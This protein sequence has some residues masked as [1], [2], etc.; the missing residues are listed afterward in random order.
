MQCMDFSSS[1]SHLFMMVSVLLGSGNDML[2]YTSVDQYWQSRGVV[3]SVE[4]M[5]AELKPANKDGDISELIDALGAKEFRVREDASKKILARGEAAIPQLEQVVRSKRSAEILFRSRALLK[6]LKG[7]AACRTTRRLMAIRALG[8]LHTKNPQALAMLRSLLHS[9]KP[10]EAEFAKYAIA[11]IEGKKLP[12]PAGPSQAELDEDIW[13]L[14]R[15]CHLVMQL[16][17]TDYI[18]VGTKWLVRNVK[19]DRYAPSPN[20]PMLQAKK[21]HA[22]QCINMLINQIGNARIDAV[23]I[24]ATQNHCF[25]ILRGQY[26]KKVLKAFLQKQKIQVIQKGSLDLITTLEPSEDYSD[27]KMATAPSSDPW[28]VLESYRFCIILESN[29]RII[30]IQPADTSWWCQVLSAQGEK[31]R[32]SCTHVR[33]K[34]YKPAFACKKDVKKGSEPKP[35]PK[36]ISS[37][38]KM[39]TVLAS[40]EKQGSLAKNAKMAALIR[41]ADRTKPFWVVAQLRKTCNVKTDTDTKAKDKPTKSLMSDQITFT[42]E[43]RGE[44]FHG[45][46]K[47]NGAKGEQIGKAVNILDKGLRNTRSTVKS[48]SYHNWSTNAISRF[49]WRL[50]AK[51][52]GDTIHL[53]TKA[54]D[55]MMPS[56]LSLINPFAQKTSRLLKSS[57]VQVDVGK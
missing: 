32:Q 30:C 49:L 31:M 44:T 18:P 45:T 38:E 10:F 23:T 54:T 11:K 5:V 2:D 56:V 25:T 51:Q 6:D 16:A 39:V 24:G 26:D 13:L 50:Q 22:D 40:K 42:A 53:T 52:E 20:I 36:K 48:W 27:S 47:I 4:N 21:A 8:Q 17:S 15:E 35:R 43:R 9:T 12:R 37:W 33:K 1:W 57:R 14:P 7:N 3:V 46:L 34:M 19:A 29:S 55:D 41:S 28:D